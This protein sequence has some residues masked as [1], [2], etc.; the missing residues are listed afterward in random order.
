MPP[1]LQFTFVITDGHIQV[2][3]PTLAA[4]LEKKDNSLWK[5]L[6]DDALAPSHSWTQY[7]EMGWE[8]SSTSSSL[9]QPISWFVDV[10]RTLF[11]VTSMPLNRSRRKIMKCR[12]SLEQIL[13]YSIFEQLQMKYR[14]LPFVKNSE[15]IDR[16][17]IIK[18]E[19][20]LIMSYIF[21]NLWLSYGELSLLK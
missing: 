13:P 1:L 21:K 6:P 3:H 15:N 17:I 7:W 20:Y 2:M 10:T 11:A 14:W 19:Y 4:S 16:L 18:H 5:W 9:P 8:A 12:I